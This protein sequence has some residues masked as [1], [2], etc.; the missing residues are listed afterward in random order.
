MNKFRK[1]ILTEDIK[2]L[3]LKQGNIIYIKEDKLV[4][5]NYAS[6]N[7]L[8]IDIDFV[9][10]PT[11]KEYVE[12]KGQQGGVRGYI[13]DNGDLYI[14]N[15]ELIHLYGIKFLIKKGIIQNNAYSPHELLKYITGEGIPVI[16]QNGKVYIA[17][18]VEISAIREEEQRLL[19][20]YFE[21]CEK[22]NKW[23]KFIGIG[24][25]GIGL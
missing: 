7:S 8:N 22:K 21:Q 24:R 1:K 5:S 14:W 3:G 13:T 11:A 19:L 6:E 18:S 16:V 4:L 23:L 15:S 12:I 9:T 25:R 17:E 2:E 10:N 20:D